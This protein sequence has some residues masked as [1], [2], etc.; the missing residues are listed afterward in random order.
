MSSSSNEAITGLLKDLS[1]EFAL[2]DLGDLHYF[3]GIEV[4]KHDGGLHLSQEKYAID[5]VARAG[6]QGCKAAPTPLSS[7]EKL[8]LTEGKLLNQ[9]TTPGTEV[10]LVNCNI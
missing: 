5:L 7:S 2:K 3:L 8:S 4:K 9:E 6:L 1:V 10:W